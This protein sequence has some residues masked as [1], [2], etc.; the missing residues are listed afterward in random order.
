MTSDLSRLL[1]MFVRA[2]DATRVLEIGTG[3]GASGL[4]IAEALPS[5]GMLITLE[6]DA[7]HAA[8]A[9]QA[10]ATAG[11][12]HKVSVMIGDASRYL[13]KIAGPFDLVFQDGDVAQYAALHERIVGLLA[14]GGTLITHNI[15]EA[16]SYNEMLAADQRLNTATL[17]IGNG[18]AVSV[19]RKDH[20]DA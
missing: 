8:A 9:R 11:Y 7:A 15:S 2:V 19:R 14:P 5:D 17:N 6:R 1:G 12:A 13:H 3:A 4:A 18:V 10:F 20:H 16:A